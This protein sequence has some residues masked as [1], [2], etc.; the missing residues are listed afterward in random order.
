MTEEVGRWYRFPPDLDAIIAAWREA[1]QQPTMN[2]DAAGAA[3]MEVDAQT[4][5][6]N[7]PP[8]LHTAASAPPPP[9]RSPRLAEHPTLA[10]ASSSAPSRDDDHD[11]DDIHMNGA[12]EEI[13]DDQPQKPRNRKKRPHSPDVKKKLL[14]AFPNHTQQQMDDCL[15]ELVAACFIVKKGNNR[16]YL[17]NT[18]TGV[19]SPKQEGRDC[20]SSEGQVGAADREGGTIA[21]RL[22]RD[23]VRLADVPEMLEKELKKEQHKDDKIVMP[24]RSDRDMAMRHCGQHRVYITNPT[25]HPLGT[26]KPKGKAVISSGVYKSDVPG[27][28]FVKRDNAWLAQPPNNQRGKIPGRLFKITRHLPPEQAQALAE[29]AAREMWAGY[30]PRRNGKGKAKEGVPR[31]EVTGVSWGKARKRWVVTWYEGA[32]QRYAYFNPK[33]YNGNVEEARVA[34]EAFRAS[35]EADYHFEA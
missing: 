6:L 15:D 19:D 14:E 20:V 7:H 23:R 13:A 24:P 4:V 29:E 28:S 12:G 32:Q 2:D 30:G 8:T 16:Y 10:V 3:P 17:S 21:Q 18:H 9:R 27:V 5:E 33:N 35:K 34:A 22:R 11:A 26:G 1:Q 31:S 25:P